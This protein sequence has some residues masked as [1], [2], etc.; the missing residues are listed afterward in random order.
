MA[1]WRFGFWDSAAFIPCLKP[2]LGVAS[3]LGERNYAKGFDCST[4]TD[5][6]KIGL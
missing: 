1:C 3:T 4:K 5:P 2:D 6:N